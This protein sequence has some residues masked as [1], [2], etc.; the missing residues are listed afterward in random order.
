MERDG[1]LVSCAVLKNLSH[2]TSVNHL[3]VH[4]EDH[5]LD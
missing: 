1:V 5:P 3:A 4:T 2:T